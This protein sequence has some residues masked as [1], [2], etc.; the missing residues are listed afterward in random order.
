MSR[1]HLGLLA[2]TIANI[3]ATDYAKRTAAS[4]GPVAYQ[5]LDLHGLP[6]HVLAEPLFWEGNP[7]EGVKSLKKGADLE[8]L[9]CKLLSAW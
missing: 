3:K 4:D 2:C 9:G 1:V 5:A 7:A 6:L 8:K